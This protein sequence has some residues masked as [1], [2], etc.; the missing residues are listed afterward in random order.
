MTTWFSES[1]CTKSRFEKSFQNCELIDGE[2]FYLSDQGGNP[3]FST[4]VRGN[5]PDSDPEF[6]CTV[7]GEEE[8]ITP[9]DFDVCSNLLDSR[10]EEVFTCPCFEPKKILRP[11]LPKMFLKALVVTLT[12]DK[13]IFCPIK[14]A[15]LSTA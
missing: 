15:T 1:R 11:S 4:I 13:H 8:I 5:G 12:L 7:N 14:M 10:C 2:E 6:S 9:D 3:S